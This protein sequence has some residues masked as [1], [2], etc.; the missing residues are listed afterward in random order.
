[1]WGRCTAYRRWASRARSSDDL[2][3]DLDDRPQEF[4]IKARP[5]LDRRTTDVVDAA[6]TCERWSILCGGPIRSPRRLRGFETAVERSLCAMLDVPMMFWM[7][8]PWA[9]F[10]A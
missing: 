4:G 5:Q 9:M 6:L 1:M 10:R 3:Q 7:R 8:D 2:A